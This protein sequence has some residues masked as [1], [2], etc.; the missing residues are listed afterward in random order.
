[1]A[2]S[3][4]QKL[5]ALL[6]GITSTHHGNFYFLNCLHSFGIEKKLE[7]HLKVYED[8]DFSNVIM[9]SED[10]KMLEFNQYQKSDKTSFIIYAHLE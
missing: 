3:F 10:N 8:K 7:S 9:S 6:K 2:L 1:M 5:S 4:S